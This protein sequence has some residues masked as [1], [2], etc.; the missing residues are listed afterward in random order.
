M[1]ATVEPRQ[2]RMFRNAI[3]AFP[4]VWRFLEP[5]PGCIDAETT[6]PVETMLLRI[7][8]SAESEMILVT[9]LRA[10]DGEFM[11]EAQ[12]PLCAWQSA[13]DFLESIALEAFV[14]GVDLRDGRWRGSM[15]LRSADLERRRDFSYIRSWLGTY[16][17]Q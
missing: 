4:A 15:I 7:S 8:A 16:D 5:R 2:L 11:A 14:V 13:K 10:A 6:N 12:F 17:R 1:T 9:I 3:A